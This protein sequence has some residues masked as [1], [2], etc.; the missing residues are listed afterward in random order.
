MDGFLEGSQETIDAETVDHLIV[1]ALTYELKK[2]WRHRIEA[3][4]IPEMV[5][6]AWDYIKAHTR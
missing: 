5:E 1:K 2:D 6:A 4:T 3:A